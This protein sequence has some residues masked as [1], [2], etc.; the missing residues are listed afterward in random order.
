MV[1]AMQRSFLALLCA[2]V[3]LA[4]E[5]QLT[6]GSVIEGEIIAETAE[7]VQVRVTLGNTIGQRALL[8]SE[9]AQIVRG[10]SARTRA[11]TALRAEAVVLTT[12]G[13]PAT[14]WVNLAVRARTA[15]DPVLARAWAALAVARDPTQEVAQRMLGRELMQGVWMAPNEAAAVRGLVLHDHVWVTWDER[16]RL[17][18]E[19]R[20]R[21]ERQLL[22][23]AEATARRRA[24]AAASQQDAWSLPTTYSFRADTPLKVIW[25]GG[26]QL[27]WLPRPP[28]PVQP[29]GP[30]AQSWLQLKGGWGD[31][32]W[33]IRLNW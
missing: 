33:N 25:W 3:L 28:W 15:G 32:N 14:A 5:V 4:D 6:N 27:P 2:V 12:A 29:P 1:F 23:T 31:V 16:E 24:A 10:E 22:A 30:F 9:I 26:G 18:S 11:M 19:V 20:E 7:T 13:A 8:R 21:R 17:R